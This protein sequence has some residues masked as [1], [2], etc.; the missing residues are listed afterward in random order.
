[1]PLKETS[2]LTDAD[3]VT[4]FHGKARTFGNFFFTRMR[5]F[6]IRSAREWPGKGQ[7]AET[8]PMVFNFGLITRRHQG[9]SNTMAMDQKYLAGSLGA[10]GSA[11][12]R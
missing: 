8:S 7:V 3:T 11:A 5:H 4:G 10:C 6:L 2:H 1:M 9:G 12:S